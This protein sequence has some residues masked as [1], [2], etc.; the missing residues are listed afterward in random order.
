MT[1]A[2]VTGAARG[3]GRGIALVLG[4]LGATVYLTDLESR[5][6]RVSPLGHAVE[7]T[8]DEV[9]ARG[10]QGIAIPHDHRDDPKP[11][12]ERI[13]ADH[14]GLDLV[15]ANACNG[16][17]R[18]F[19]PA[20]FWDLAP[21][22]WDEM[23]TIG[24]RSHLETASRAAPLLIARRG[25]LV[26][27]GYVT[28]V[29][30]APCFTLSPPRTTSDHGSARTEPARQRPG[31]PSRPRRRDPPARPRRR[32]VRRP[33]DRG[34]GARRMIPTEYARPS[35]SSILN[36]A[37]GF[38][39]SAVGREYPPGSSANG[40]ATGSCWRSTGQ[41]S[42]FSGP[43]RATPSMSPPAGSSSARRRSTSWTSKPPAWTRRSA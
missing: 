33:D 24:V 2:L 22:H 17:A 3:V 1:V 30:L 21:Q 4:D 42:P 26:L 9:T 11:V 10:G 15:V 7:D 32:P 39:R 43:R 14:D 25:L 19:A 5:T 36:Q 6:H 37:S 28:A 29:A 38:S 41:P 34:R 23:L 20:P 40:S 8:A 27:T 18:P 13:R 16:N 35:S 31:R 12:I